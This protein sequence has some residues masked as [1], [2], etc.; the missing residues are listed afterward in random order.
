MG[1]N[2]E[3]P[4]KHLCEHQDATVND[5]QAARVAATAARGRITV[6]AEAL[7]FGQDMFKALVEIY[8]LHIAGHASG[9][10]ATKSDKLNHSN[11]L[12]AQAGG[13]ERTSCYRCQVL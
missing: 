7:I 10:F 4:A 12:K 2:S 6:Y 1:N 11:Y 9:G 8:S 13:V 3:I 5:F